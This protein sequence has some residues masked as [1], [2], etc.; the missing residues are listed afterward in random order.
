MMGGD[1]DLEGSLNDDADDLTEA[2][3]ED[4]GYFRDDDESGMTLD[5]GHGFGDLPSNNL[6][7]ANA[8]VSANTF[9]YN[10]D[11]VAIGGGD[12]GNFQNEHNA[13]HPTLTEGS[14]QYPLEDHFFGPQ[15]ANTFF[16]P[17]N[18]LASLADSLA[19]FQPR[20]GREAFID[21]FD[22]AYHNDTNIVSTFLEDPPIDFESGNHGDFRTG[23]LD[24][25]SVSP[26]HPYTPESSYYHLT[27]SSSIGES[28]YTALTIFSQAFPSSAQ[29]PI[30]DMS[31]GPGWNVHTWKQDLSSDTE[32][33]EGKKNST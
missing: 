16:D 3:E 32:P 24:N 10:H 12:S 15:T 17:E 28:S 13:V 8:G 20:E 5:N 18:D 6:T 22:D 30:D 14:N 4:L 9:A 1:D 7:A 23:V 27:S 21:H 11:S 19:T 31:S 26:Q 2:D 29:K 25:D 33:N